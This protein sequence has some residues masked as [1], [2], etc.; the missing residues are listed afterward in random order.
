MKCDIC[1]EERPGADM[2]EL[3]CKHN[4]CVQC[5]AQ[6]TGFLCPAPL[7]EGTR[8]SDVIVD[9][10]AGVEGSTATQ[11]AFGSH[12]LSVLDLEERK[13]C[14]SR[15]GAFPCVNA[16]RMY[17]INCRHRIC[18]D[19]L[20]EKIN[21]DV[22]NHDV[23][24]CPLPHCSNRISRYEVRTLANR[25]PN[26]RNLCAIAEKLIVDK[27]G[28]I[29]AGKEEIVVETYIYGREATNK[30]IIIP[31]ICI[32]VDLINAVLQL[33]RLARNRSTSSISIFVR[34][35][36]EKGLYKYEMLVTKEIGR[37]T[38]KDLNWGDPT[39]V[40]V[41]LDNQLH[42]H[43]HR[44]GM[45]LGLFGSS[46]K[47]QPL[48]SIDSGGYKERKE[49]SEKDGRGTVL[50]LENTTVTIEKKLAEGGF[51]I[52]YLVS[53]RHNRHYA[54]KRQFINDD[55]KQ[56][57][58]CRR[59]FQI[60][61]SLKGHKNIV[62]YV[63]HLLAKN[64]SGIYD[65]MLLTA[66]YKTS[67]LQLMNDRLLVGQ[68]LR[69]SEVLSI[70]C[71]MCEAVA[72]LH[73]SV[74]PIVHRD[75]K[76][77]NIL[78]DER[79][80][81]APP[82]Y[83]LCDFGSATTKVLSSN[84]Y[85]ISFIQDEIEKYTTLSYRSPE[86]IDLYCGKA[87][88]TKSDIWA[89]GVMLYKLCYF[90]L[91]FGES[92]MAIQNGAF[93]F[94][95]EPHHADSIKAIIKCLLDA[96]I[97]RRPTIY[98][99][100]VLAFA[101]AERP[102]PIR[103]VK[104][105]RKPSLSAAVQRFLSGNVSVLEDETENGVSHVRAPEQRN[106]LEQNVTI[107]NLAPESSLG[108]PTGLTTSV[109]P[110]LRPK[111]SLSTCPVP[112]VLQD[113]KHL[114]SYAGTNEEGV[115]C[116]DLKSGDAPSKK[117]SIAESTAIPSDLGFTDL[118]VTIPS[119]EV[120]NKLAAS[121]P[122]SN[123]NPF[124]QFQN[125]NWTCASLEEST[126]S[127]ASLPAPGKS[128]PLTVQS[129]R[130]NTSDTS[131]IIRSAFKPYSQWKSVGP[132]S[133]NQTSL[134]SLGLDNIASDRSEDSWN[135]FLAAPFGSRQTMDDS[136][137]G[138]CFD[139]LPRKAE[140]EKGSELMSSSCDIDQ[141]SIDSMDP[142]GAAPFD[143]SFCC[144]INSEKEPELKCR[145][146]AD[147]DSVGSTSDLHLRATEEDSE[148]DEQRMVARRRFSYE[149][150]DGVG[151]DASSD[152]RGR[153]DHDSTDEIS[154]NEESS[155]DEFNVDCESSQ[156]T[157]VAG[158]GS[159]DDGVGSRPLLEDDALD[160]DEEEAFNGI[161]PSEDQQRLQDAVNS[162]F[163]DANVENPT[164]KRNTNPFLVC[165]SDDTPKIS[166]VLPPAIGATMWTEKDSGIIDCYDVAQRTFF[167]QRSAPQQQNP[168]SYIYAPA[169]LP[170]QATPLT[171]AP[172][173]SPRPGGN[174]EAPLVLGGTLTM[175]S[176]NP[177]ISAIS[178]APQP[179]LAQK[180]APVRVNI[181]QQV[182]TNEP[183]MPPVVEKD[184]PS[185]PAKQSFP[186]FADTTDEPKANIAGPV[187]NVGPSFIEG[188]K[189]PKPKKSK[190]KDKKRVDIPFSGS[191]VETDGSEAEMCTST[192]SDKTTS[193][194]KRKSFGLLGSN[195]SV[196]PLDLKMSSGASS[197]LLKKSSVKK[198]SSSA[199]SSSR[200]GS[201]G[202]L[203]ASFIN[204][205]FLAEDLDSPP[206]QHTIR[207]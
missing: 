67:V 105:C 49:T 79:N 53:D 143:D 23:L 130:R 12:T 89:L 174:M 196:A 132:L 87:I 80:R 28:E 6:Y 77:E 24:N 93:S 140:N 160:D 162:L 54:L 168:V 71:D 84:N 73:H 201:S 103:N 4:F 199:V 139:E 55:N 122:V 144:Q 15:R 109:Q 136:H 91:P 152:S 44:K 114:P 86:M 190:E 106:D 159:D 173:P 197:A 163:V 110:R 20:S 102:C 119:P 78:I 33:Q 153:T 147:A 175:T 38:V 39:Y 96:D 47:P 107:V 25:S 17:L 19:C 206:K 181:M 154:K 189:T 68:S 158:V 61:S 145:E 69:S 85:S 129:H 48:T 165:A 45:P 51:A 195:P 57:E 83:V 63:D 37:K 21:H 30:R 148:Q 31:K 42:H 194:K 207:M 62:S 70:F 156:H 150:I 60:V 90:C 185:I 46:S 8:S 178:A 135:P 137:F 52:V 40:V 186:T 82:I 182:Q 59:E 88:G 101:A 27:C 16:A 113:P 14:E 7:C 108:N 155:Y 65:Y 81:A 64:K 120:Q 169:T 198:A 184:A 95:N 112:F 72:R 118:E 187:K 141:C 176:V 149:N 146:R 22:T 35:E 115:L 58:A 5:L 13:R 177:I 29:K 74:T 131:H 133:C 32:I 111:P 127:T 104:G 167:C 92:A 10:I 99:C 76:V 97:E 179:V 193:K 151:D 205:S 2:Q 170:R 34:H 50:R 166:P 171:A 18:Y 125:V 123:P 75:L 134:S 94:P 203:N 202:A 11:I 3:S 98:Q 183:R 36:M 41:D 100:S 157:D 124:E 56:V 128:A 116:G 164:C 121:K 192:S 180:P 204:S 66:Y 188:P 43:N 138:K 126:S 117:T 26:L 172:R 142:F 191:E 1:T 9:E 200:K 161:P